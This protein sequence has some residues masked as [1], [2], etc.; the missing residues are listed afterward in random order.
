ML[1]KNLQSKQGAHSPG[2]CPVFSP[3]AKSQSPNDLMDWLKEKKGT[4]GAAAK[5]WGRHWQTAGTGREGPPAG[6]GDA[7]VMTERTGYWGSP[8]F[9]AGQAA[10]KQPA[11]RGF[12]VPTT[13]SNPTAARKSGNFG[14]FPP[15]NL[16]VC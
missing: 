15:G 4:G 9:T 5:M 10:G 7:V 16:S 12:P 6:E 3:S 13:G 11:A 2:L 14:D 1:C 8:C